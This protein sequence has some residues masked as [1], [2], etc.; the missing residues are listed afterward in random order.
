[1][2]CPSCKSEYRTGFTRCSDCDVDLVESLVIDDELERQS[3]WKGNSQADCVDACKELREADIPYNVRQTPMGLSGGMDVDFKYEIDVS[4]AD[5]SRAVSILRNEESLLDEHFEIPAIDAPP[6]KPTRDRSFRERS[7][8]SSLE[9]DVF[10]QPPEN[11]SSIVELSLST[12]SIPFQTEVDEDGTR[13]VF[14]AAE[15]ESLAREIIRQ[16][17]EGTP[18]E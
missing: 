3:V 2:F 10:T 9:I 12:N 11:T 1:M 13:R 4:K 8:S 6:I 16:I 7:M 14:V 15:D 18:P 17:Q 5:S